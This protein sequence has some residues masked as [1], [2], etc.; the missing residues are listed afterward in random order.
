MAN[1]SNKSFSIAITGD[2]SISSIAWSEIFNGLS[3]P[4]SP[5]QSEIKDLALGANTITPPTGGGTT[6]VGVLIIPPSTNANALTLKGI[7]GDTGVPISKTDM[8]YIGLGA[9]GTFV[10]NAAALT[11]GVRFI[12]I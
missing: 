2:G 3:N 1:T 12:W 9:A 4:L 7:A 10:I 5:A 8:T 11:S 6:P